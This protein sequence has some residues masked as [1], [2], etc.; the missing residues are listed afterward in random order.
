MCTANISAIQGLIASVKENSTWQTATIRNVVI[1]LGYNPADE[2]MKTS[3]NFQAILRIVPN[4]GRRAVF[5]VL[6]ITAK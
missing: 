3:K 2:R 6:S 1:A 5:P 4:M